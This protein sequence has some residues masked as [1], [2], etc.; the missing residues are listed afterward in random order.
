MIRDCLI[1]SLI[2]ALVSGFKQSQ[3]LLA[4]QKK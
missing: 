2:L 1:F 3:N 4:K